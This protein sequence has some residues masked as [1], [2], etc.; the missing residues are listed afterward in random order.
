V[1]SYRDKGIL[2]DVQNTWQGTPGQIPNNINDVKFTSD[3]LNYLESR[4][5]VNKSRIFASGKSNGGG[6]TNFLACDPVLSKRIAAF[7]PVAGSYYVENV[8][9]SASTPATLPI[10]CNPGRFKIPIIIFHSE[11]DGTISYNGGPRK[12]A[13]LPAIPR[14]VHE[15]ARRDGLGLHNWTSHLGS[16]TSIYQYGT[17]LDYG[18]VTHV[19]NTVIGHDWPATIPNDDNTQEGRTGPASFNATPIIME[20]FLRHPLTTLW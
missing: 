3:I 11:K 5:C 12:G 6:F 15:W 19:K 1:L 16:D 13:C 7:A 14:I 2:T 8:N 20:F 17:G 9:C 4:Y 10:T 18:L